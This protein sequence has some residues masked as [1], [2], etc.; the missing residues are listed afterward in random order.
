MQ[1]AE[2]GPACGH[3]KCRLLCGQLLPP[4]PVPR[5]V[6]SGDVALG[7]GG[8]QPIPAAH[9]LAFK[10]P[11][12][13]RAP[14]QVASPGR[15]AGCIPGCCALCSAFSGAPGRMAL[16]DS[17]RNLVRLSQPWASSPSGCGLTGPTR[18]RKQRSGCFDFWVFIETGSSY[19]SGRGAVV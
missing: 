17:G 18:V 1:S 13:H 19:C 2:A 15:G 14:C 7:L 9:P 5:A 11:L 10:G 12:G 3:A 8:L 16:P 4:P 6:W